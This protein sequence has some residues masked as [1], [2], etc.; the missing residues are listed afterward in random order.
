[1]DHAVLFTTLVWLN[2][3]ELKLR[4]KLLE[5]LNTTTSVSFN[6][7]CAKLNYLDTFNTGQVKERSTT[8]S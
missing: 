4:K 6:V 5:E 1:M 7:K 3:S 8:K 2:G